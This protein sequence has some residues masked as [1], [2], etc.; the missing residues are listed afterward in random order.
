MA[1]LLEQS[2]KTNFQNGGRL[3]YVT[4]GEYGDSGDSAHHQEGKPMA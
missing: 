1:F 4:V 3:G 2:G